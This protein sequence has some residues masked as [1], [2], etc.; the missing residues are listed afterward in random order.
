MWSFLG[1]TTLDTLE[2]LSSIPPVAGEALSNSYRAEYLFNRSNYNTRPDISVIVPCGHLSDYRKSPWGCFRKLKSPCSHQIIVLPADS[3]MHNYL[4]FD[5]IIDERY[6]II[7]GISGVGVGGGGITYRNV[8]SRIYNN[9]FYEIGDTVTLVCTILNN[10]D[11][12][13]PMF[14]GWNK[15]FIAIDKSIKNSIGYHGYIVQGPDTVIG[16]FGLPAFGHLAANNISTP[17]SVIA[18]MYMWRTNEKYMI[19]EDTASTIFSTG[20]WI[21]GKT[22]SNKL[23]L[24]ASKYLTNS[25]G[26]DYYPGPLRTSNG[27]TTYETAM[28]YNKTWH[29][30]RAMIDEHIARVGTSGYTVPEDIL[31][32]PGNGDIADGYAAQL[33]PYYDADSNGR[34]NA[35]AGDYPIIRGDEAVFTIFND[36]TVTHEVSKGEPMGVEIHAMFYAFNE[37]SDTALNN[38]VFVHY[39]IYNRSDSNYYNTYLGAFADFDVG[40]SHSDYIGC[41]VARGMFYGYKGY[42]GVSQTANMFHGKWPAQSCTF[43][44]GA[45]LPADNTDNPAISMGDTIIHGDTIGNCGINGMNFGNGIADDERMGMTNFTYYNNSTSGINGDPF[46]VSDFYN[47]MRGFWKNGTKITYGGNGTNTSALPC[48]FMFPHNSDPWHWGTNGVVSGFYWSESLTDT[49]AGASANPFGDRRGI[50]AS[51]PFTFEAGT[52]QQL[53]LA[54]TTSF[55]AADSNNQFFDAVV[56]LGIATDNVLRQ[57]NRDTTD[58]GKPFTYMPYSAPH[59]VGIDEAVQETTNI[60]VYP[61][62]TNGLLKVVETGNTK[63]TKIQLFDMS[64]RLLMESNTEK[65]YTTLNLSELRN[66]IYVLKADTT[67]FRIVK[68]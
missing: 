27:S 23:H 41:D 32:W 47:Y 18:N 38:T 7:E 16:Y 30:S 24:A 59:V 60:L 37:P 56:V 43:L 50:G 9:S 54:Y 29:I 51:G 65:G 4:K 40:Y 36:N 28:R 44:G 42:D 49:S 35:Y 48:N 58:S 53:D 17:V 6:K 34:Y 63:S 26:Y 57:F 21:G 5:D 14:F 68:K 55:V 12:I 10:Y 11:S 33:A 62:P 52:M 45:Y 2:F 1:C 61:N 19:V 3:T 64:G 67:V 66:G 20:L 22:D 15:P 46:Q 13:Q 39:D 25:Y 8:Y 31:T